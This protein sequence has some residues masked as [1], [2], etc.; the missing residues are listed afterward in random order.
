LQREWGVTVALALAS[1]AIPL[2]IYFRISSSYEKGVPKDLL[3]K[4]KS[5]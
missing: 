3:A 1:I 5:N 2:F 4:K